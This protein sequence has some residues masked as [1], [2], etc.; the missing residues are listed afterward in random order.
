MSNRPRQSTIIRRRA[1]REHRREAGAAEGRSRPSSSRRSRSGSWRALAHGGKVILFGNGGSAADA[2]HLAAEF[3]GPL[4]VRPRSAPGALLVRQR[5]GGDRDRQRLRLRARPSRG[6][7]AHLATRA[8]SRSGFR[9]AA[10]RRTSWT[11]C[12]P[13]VGWASTPRASR[14]R[15]APR[16]P[17]SPDACV[18]VPSTVT[19]RIQEAY[20]LYAHIMCELV[21]EELFGAQRDALRLQPAA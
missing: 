17:T 6:R 19:A 20:M 2:T 12:A 3:V 16:W 11:A 8:T 14:V 18:M 21:E 13:P 9:R 5:L 4:P 10:R 1:A 15:A 7:S